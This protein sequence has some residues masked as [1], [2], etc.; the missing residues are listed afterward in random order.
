[1]IF[2]AAGTQDGREL[3][4]YLLTQGYDVTVSVVSDYGKSLLPKHERLTV[5][6]EPLDKGQL[7]EYLT[8]HA[9]TAVVDASHPYAAQ[10][11]ANAMDVCRELNL[12]YIRYERPGEPIAYDKIYAAEN[13]G[14]AA[15]LAAQYADGGTVFLTTGSRS[16]PIFCRHPALQNNRLIARVLP[17]SDVMTACEKLGLSPKNIVAVQGPFSVDLNRALFSAYETKVVV[18]KD[19]ARLGGLDTKIAAAAA[20]SLPVVV[21]ARPRLAYD[22]MATDFKAVAKFLLGGEIR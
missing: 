11:S 5:N 12:P 3:T 16:L 9:I 17:T 10:I 13:Y 20:L 7:K 4:E 21:I 22:N 8:R 19:T 6:A 2:V 14:Q 1:M 15:E 18:T